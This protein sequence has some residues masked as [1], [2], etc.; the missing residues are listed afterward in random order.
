MKSNEEFLTHEMCDAYFELAL[1]AI[2]LRLPPV[3]AVLKQTTTLNI[4]SSYAD[5][6]VV[7]DINKIT[8]EIS[9]QGLAGPKNLRSAFT[10]LNRMF[11]VSMWGVLQGT[12]IYPEISKHPTIQF[13]RHVRN[14]CAHTGTFNFAALNLPANWRDKEITV[15]QIGAVVFPKFLM[16]GDVILLVL[17]VNNQFFAPLEL[18]L[19]KNPKL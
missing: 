2:T 10:A 3:Q 18:M 5:Q 1:G 11:L 8:A 9:R 7:L 14:A 15:A 17:D 13:F 12:K 4:Q 16:D 19:R 6:G